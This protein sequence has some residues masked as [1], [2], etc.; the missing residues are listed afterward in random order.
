MARFGLDHD[1]LRASKPD[2]GHLLAHG[3]RRGRG[4]SD[5]AR[6]RHHRAG[7][8]GP[9]ELHGR[10]RRRADEGRRRAAR[11][12]LR[13][14]TRRTRSW[15]R[16]RAR[17]GPD[18]A[19]TS[20]VSLFDAS[21]A[22]LVNQAANHLLGGV[23]PEPMGNAHPN[24]VP[25]QLFR[26]AGSPV[27]PRGRQR[28][29]VRAHLRRRS[30]VPELAAR[31]AV[32]D[33]R[34][35]R[36]QPRRADP[37]AGGCVR[38]RDPRRRG[39]TTL[40]AAAGP[41]RP[42]PDGRRGV[43]LAGGRGG[44]SR[45]ST[46]RPRD[47]CAWSPTRSGSTA[48]A[49][50][51]AGRRRGSASTRTR[52]SRA[53]GTLRTYRRERGGRRSRGRR[54]RRSRWSSIRKMRP[55]VSRARRSMNRIRPGRLLEHEDVQRDARLRQPHRLGEREADRLGDRRPVEERLV[56]LEV[57]GRLAVGHHDHLPRRARMLGEQPAREV[58]RVLHVRAVDALPARRR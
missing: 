51:R 31:R 36:P 41:V 4:G 5:A 32:R 21:V 35:S 37:D 49:C 29:P 15:P 42:R 1:A 38:D 12:D 6:L 40:E 2:A 14:S 34:G 23:V 53:R 45:R 57:R 54:T 58:E 20:R 25:Y 56:A 11:R 22:A 52:S 3:V 10:A 44:R 19:G 50:R 39:S 47:R 9:D 26:A 30:A 28:P 46:T 55:A 43:R 8:L 13:A 16:C 18:A 27:H 33:E 48:S 24:I 7:A 17:R